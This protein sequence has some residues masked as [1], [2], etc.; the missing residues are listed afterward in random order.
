MLRLGIVGL[1]NVGKTTLFN[2]LARAHA[3]AEN[4]PFCTVEPN[5]AVVEVPDP[6]LDRLF[7]ILSPP[8]RVPAT[9]EFFDIAGLVEGASRGEGLGNR[10]LAK[11][12]EVD[13]VVHVVRCFE[14]GAVSHVTGSVDPVR[15]RAI[16]QAELALADLETVEKALDRATREARSGDR[17]AQAQGSVLERVRDRLARGEPARAA[18]TD[19]AAR[20]ALRGLH[21]LTAKPV[22]YV[23]NLG[24]PST[25][26]AD[27]R[28]AALRSA[29]AAEEPDARVLPLAVEWEAELAGLDPQEGAELRG[30]AGLEPPGLPRLVR[31]GYA[32]L[33][34]LTFFTFNE[35]EVRAWTVRRGAR[36]PE[37]AG[38]IHTDFERGFIRAEVIGYDEFVRIGSL[39]EARDLGRV[40]G[41]G[42]D[43]VV[44]DGDLLLFRFQA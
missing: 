21:L 8:R 39:K 4:Y 43:Y 35:K 31:E 5:V 40:R 7:E 18:A 30:L 15:D 44:Q 34:L 22:L 32:L 13:A 36:A 10:F 33:G 25:A 12:R 27:P 11:I 9:V 24:D 19:A 3:P 14:S 23:A 17:E 16:V 1:P 29:V 37:A 20:D 41:E 42:K 26:D 28:V 2:A 6:R 38:A